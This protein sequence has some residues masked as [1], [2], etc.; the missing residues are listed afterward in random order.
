MVGAKEGFCLFNL[1]AIPIS[2]LGGKR[3]GSAVNILTVQNRFH[4]QRNKRGGMMSSQI[5]FYLSCEY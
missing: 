5:N 4:M 3:K 2:P 1:K